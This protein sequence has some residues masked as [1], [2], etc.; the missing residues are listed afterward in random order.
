MI[1]QDLIWSI[2]NSCGRWWDVVVAVIAGVTAFSIFFRSIMGHH[3]ID[4]V[5]VARTTVGVSLVLATAVLFNS[6]WT[7]PALG[8]MVIGIAFS[9]FLIS[10]DWCGRAD[11]KTT[12]LVAGMR[13]L[14][15]LISHAVHGERP[16]V[17]S[18][19]R[20]HNRD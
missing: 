8:L 17:V 2:V 12:L 16:R 7:K 4:A 15:R 18:S 5:F 1:W 13:L 10:I 20:E 14:G 3:K 19:L 9:Q 11:Q 6:G